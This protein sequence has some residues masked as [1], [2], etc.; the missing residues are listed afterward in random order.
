MYISSNSN[1]MHNFLEDNSLHVYYNFYLK[2]ECRKYAKK[3]YL[4]SVTVDQPTDAVDSFVKT[5]W[6]TLQLMCALYNI[7]VTVFQK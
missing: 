3:Y 4:L 1:C 6:M 5:K 7:T 2:I